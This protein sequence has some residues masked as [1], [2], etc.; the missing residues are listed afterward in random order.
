MNIKAL[1]KRLGHQNI[2]ITLNKYAHILDEMDRQ[3]N[4]LVSQ[5]LLDQYKAFS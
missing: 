2:Q 3:Q 5:V 1:S 4:E